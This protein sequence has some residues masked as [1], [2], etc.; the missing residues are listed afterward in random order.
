MKNLK[1]IFWVVIIMIT[2]G[3]TIFIYFNYYILDRVRTISSEIGNVKS[4]LGD[5]SKKFNGLSLQ[6]LETDII[7]EQLDRVEDSFVDPNNPLPFLE[8]LEGLSSSVKIEISSLSF[9]E[10]E[11]EIGEGTLTLSIEGDYEGC[12]IFVDRLQTSPYLIEI[13]RSSI[14]PTE[15]ATRISLSIN[16]MTYE[17]H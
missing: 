9:D 3:A 11:E 4:E 16:F 12:M 17:E 14:F 1:K 8:H 13:E 2:L 6:G 5:F 15:E 10:S 7:K